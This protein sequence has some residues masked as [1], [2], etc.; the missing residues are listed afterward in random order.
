MSKLQADHAG[1]IAPPPLIYVGALG[2]G[3]LLQRAAPIPFL[4]P[5]VGRVIGAC[6]I[7]LNFLLGAPAAMTMRRARTALNPMQPTTA[8]VSSG[9]FRYSRNPIYL[10]F[11]ILY[12]GIAFVANAL[13]PLL[14][15]PAVL[16]AMNRGVIEREEQYLQRKFGA[17]YTRY[18]DQVRRWL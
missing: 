17:E 16:V 12:A 13:W 7:A 2:L 3:L 10:S 15:L 18:K 5:R 1:V 11:T 6:L 14:L 4:P 8:I 9:P